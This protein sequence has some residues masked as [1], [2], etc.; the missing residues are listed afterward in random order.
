MDHSAIFWRLEQ[1]PTYL[2]S[3]GDL[4]VIESVSE[5]ELEICG[6]TLWNSE[7]ELIDKR[8]CTAG[9]ELFVALSGHFSFEIV[10]P[11]GQS[12]FVELETPDCGIW[13]ASGTHILVQSHDAKS[14]LLQ[15]TMGMIEK[16]L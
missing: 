12:S 15:V 5:R 16:A 14:V 10:G 4:S 11:T 9:E 8:L 13:V 2:D 1:L 7:K 6:F 3:R